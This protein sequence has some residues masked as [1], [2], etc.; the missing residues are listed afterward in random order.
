MSQ[1]QSNGKYVS[2]DLTLTTDTGGTGVLDAV[3][4]VAQCDISDLDGVQLIL[5]QLTDNGTVTLITDYSVDGTNFVPAV[6]TKTEADFAAGANLSIAAYSL[7]DANG[8]PLVAKILRV[9]DTVHTGTG[10]Y[11]A[12]VSGRQ[13]QNY[14]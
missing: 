5:N 4:D 1:N 2:R 10:T 3:G 8:M 6:A 14:R 9:R 7:S 12:T 11:S 13:T